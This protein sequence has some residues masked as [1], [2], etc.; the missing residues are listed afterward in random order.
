MESIEGAAKPHEVRVHIQRKPYESPSPTTGEALYALGKAP[1]GFELF[2][3][4][5]GNEEDELV[6]KDGEPIH[7]KPDEHFYY[8]DVITIIVNSRKREFDK[9]R[10]TFE[11]VIALAFNPLPENTRFKVK[12]SNGR[13]DASGSLKPGHS[14]KV[15]DGMI[16]NVSETYES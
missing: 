11:E 2:R 3:E 14:V 5:D 6:Q 13:H 12:Y 9:R 16:F 15:K 4:V 7:L 10:I 8:E 1:H